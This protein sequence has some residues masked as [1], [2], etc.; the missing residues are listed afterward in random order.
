MKKRLNLLAFAFTIYSCSAYA[1]VSTDSLNTLRNN[2]TFKKVQ[3]KIITDKINC[4]SN[5]STQVKLIQTCSSNP[6]L[7]GTM[8]FGSAAKVVIHNGK[9]S[10]DT[11]FIA[12]LC[13]STF[14]DTNKVYS[15]SISTAPNFSVNFCNGQ[16]Y[17]SDWN[18]N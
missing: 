5:K 17:N 9:Y 15:T 11:V 18:Y 1:Q 7:C 12:T 8:A 2:L 16:T 6:N 4:L 10:G 3:D 13:N 14:Y